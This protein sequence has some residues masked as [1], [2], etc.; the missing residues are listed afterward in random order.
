M[1][2]VA[3][4]VRAPAPRSQTG[5]DTAVAT[6]SFRQLW[7]GA[8]VCALAFGATAGASALSY[9]SSFGTPASRH[10]LVATTSTDKGLAILLGP[11]SAVG[12]VGG[13]TVYKGFVFLTTIGA[14]WAILA[15]TRVLRGEEDSGRWQLVLSGSTRA[16]RATGSVVAALIAAIAVVFAGTTLLTSL[17]GLSPDVGFDFGATVAYGASLTI[18][19]A[20]FAGVGAVT[21]Q[22]GRSRR[23]A[24]SLGIA[25][26]GVTFVL[27]MIADSGSGLQWMRWT[28]PFGWTELMEPFTR[29][30]LWPLVPALATTGILFGAA[31]VLASRRDVGDGVLASHDV[32][33]PRA[34]GLSSPFGI[35]ARLELPVLIG[36]C[37]GAA[38][39]GLVLGV[40]SELTTA[41][42]PTS[43]GDTLDRFGVHGTFSSQY[44]GV[45]FLLVA[46]V[47]ALLPAGQVGA[48]SDEQTSGR[49]ALVL[50]SPARRT[51]W[52]A[53]RLVLAAAAIIVAGLLAGL[54][55]WVGAAVQGIGLELGTMIGAGLNVVPTALV[56]LGIGAVMAGVAPRAASAAVYAVVIWSLLV[57][58]LGSMVSGASSLEH[59]SLFHSMALAPAQTPTVANVMI[60]TAIALALGIGATLLFGRRDV[61][62]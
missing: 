25:V 36:W 39:S 9:A 2:T 30:D 47:V 35:A 27:R 16:S 53:G 24:T 54:A 52:F 18:P 11:V 4:A 41:K 19:V 17:A 46:T 1:T 26:F 13:Y 51:T 33:R 15:A 12:A 57:D 28:T 48:M 22:L 32:A 49:L 21:S 3:P 14:L 42:L 56:A 60:T 34:F 23:R 31:V 40:I 43:I 37:A 61:H 10:Q 55:A 62:A 5:V 59:L 6:R 58:L 50:A 7:I 8:S 45:A 29:N 44:F 20:V 38:A